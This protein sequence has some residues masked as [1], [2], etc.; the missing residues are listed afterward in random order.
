MGVRRI[1]SEMN[2]PP[3]KMVPLML[4][5]WSEQD[6]SRFERN[7]TF[8]SQLA[9]LE[10]IRW[11]GASDTA[12]EAATALAGEMRILIPLANLIDKDAEIERLTKEITKLKTNLEKTQA[13]LNNPGFADKAPTNV[14]EQARHQAEEQAQAIT[15]LNEQLV[16]IKAL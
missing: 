11:L 5:N 6:K 10:A 1:R 13:R 9:K 4:E 16:K 3:G 2:I 8:I 14:V 15:A 7:T 12:P